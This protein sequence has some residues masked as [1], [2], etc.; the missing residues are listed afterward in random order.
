MTSYTDYLEDTIWCNDRS[1]DTAYGTGLGYGTNE[2]YYSSFN[3]IVY[4]NISLACTNKKDRFTLSTSNGNGS[5]TYMV[6]L[7]TADEIAYAGAVYGTA[8]STYYLYTGEYW[9]SLSPYV[10]F[11]GYAF[12][13]FVVDDGSLN[14]NYNVSLNTGIRPVVSL[15]PG[16]MISSG[17]GTTNSPYVIN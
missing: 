15:T 6:A 13:W 7:L 1:I 10:F 5:L 2:T 8:N 16:T 14:F 17:N 11:S 3:R 9:W 12:V 4:T